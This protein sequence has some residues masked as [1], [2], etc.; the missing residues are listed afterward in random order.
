MITD[1]EV[2]QALGSVSLGVNTL[3]EFSTPPTGNF[4]MATRR[5]LDMTRID[6]DKSVEIPGTGRAHHPLPPV[7][8]HT[9]ITW[10]HRNA[11]ATE[12]ATTASSRKLS[13]DRDALSAE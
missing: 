1:V 6:S 9:S 8:G 5:P 10:R 7:Y 2:G 12:R 4:R 13:G 11:P 3:P